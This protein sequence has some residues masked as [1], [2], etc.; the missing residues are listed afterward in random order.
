MS[1]TVLLLPFSDLHLWILTIFFYWKRD[2]VLDLLS[3]TL[4]FIIATT[5]GLS[6]RFK[7][8]LWKSSMFVLFSL[9][10]SV[11]YGPHQLCLWSGMSTLVCASVLNSR[12]TPLQLGLV[13]SRHILQ[14]HNCDVE[15]TAVCNIHRVGL[16]LYLPST[17]TGEDIS[18]YEHILRMHTFIFSENFCNTRLPPPCFLSA[19]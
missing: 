17:V 19:H 3:K 7:S 18:G 1:C 11:F 15:R 8:I 9:I 14:L 16:I 13:F 12:I 10:A 5:T 4:A 2:W 6:G